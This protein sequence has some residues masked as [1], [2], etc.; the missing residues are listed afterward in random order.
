MKKNSAQKSVCFY[1]QVHQPVRL[2][3]FSFF[4]IEEKPKYDY[5]QGLAPYNNEFYIRKVANKCYYPTNNLLDE[6]LADYP[7]FKCAFSISGVALEQFQKFDP[8]I[9]ASF[10]QLV[11]TKKVELLNE[12]YY[13]SLSFLY[14]KQEFAE[15]IGLHRQLIWKLFRRKPKIFRNT[16]LIYNNEIGNFVRLLG[17]K[18]IL[19]EGWD[20]YLKGRSPNNVYHAP[21]ISTLDTD[22]EVAERYR[23][24]KSVPRKISLLLKNYKLSDDIAFRFSDKT[25]KEYPLMVEKFVDWV[26][27][28]NGKTVNLFMDFET[29]GEH[30]WEDSGI[31]NFMRKLPQE[32]L[33]R[34]ISFRTPSETIADFEPEEEMDIHNLVSWADM[35]RDVSAWLGNK[36]QNEAARRIYE[37][38][39]QVRQMKDIVHDKDLTENIFTTWRKLQ[40]S[41]HFYYMSTKYW[42]DGDIHTYFSPYDSPY[43][44]YINYMNIL[45]D[46]SLELE[47]VASVKTAHER[48]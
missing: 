36:M 19:A 31:F 2:S 8:N 13:H 5:F 9:I 43:D 15:Q 40:T 23:F 18:G 1:F 27:A 21:G 20:H 29:F 26:E 48:K 34:G 10:K 45:S 14:S 6:L 7:E 32:L 41:D 25:W 46:F 17:F 24:G 44:A 33:R 42:S 16:E 22:S 35:E 39:G 38:E 3:K 47:K 4:D 11:D 28:C 12:T 37:I 30:Q